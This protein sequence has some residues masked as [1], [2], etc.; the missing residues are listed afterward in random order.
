M[1]AYAI[2]E[3]LLVGS[4]PLP[5]YLDATKLLQDAS[6]EVDSYVGSIYTTPLD[7]SE[8]SPMT[9]PARLL[10]KRITTHIATGR[11]ILATA[12]AGEDDRLH[13]YGASLLKEGLDALKMIASGDVVLEGADKTQSAETSAHTPLIYNVDSESNVEAFYDRVMKPSAIYPGA[14]R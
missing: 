10:V 2:E 5:T 9:R 3:D 1:V 8:Q 7:L 12:A 4:I 6:D 14:V 13:Q 11:M